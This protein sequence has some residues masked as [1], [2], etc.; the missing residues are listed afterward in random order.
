MG[1][2]LSDVVFFGR[3][4]QQAHRPAANQIVLIQGVTCS[5]HWNDSGLA[6]SQNRAR[7]IL[8]A[9][10]QSYRAGKFSEIKSTGCPHFFV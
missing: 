10:I 8:L 5:R 6:F 7:I 9:Q 4:F 1:G 2:F 3:V